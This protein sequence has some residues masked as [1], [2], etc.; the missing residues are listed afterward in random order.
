M[1]ERKGAPGKD[2]PERSLRAKRM[3]SAAIHAAE[4]ASALKCLAMTLLLPLLIAYVKRVRVFIGLR[5]NIPL[6]KADIHGASAHRW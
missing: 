4:I 2:M 5:L 3:R 6:S 1:T